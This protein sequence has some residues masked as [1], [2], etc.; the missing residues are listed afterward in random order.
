MASPRPVAAF[1]GLILTAAF[2]GPASASGQ[3][4]KAPDS[5]L[6]R[7]AFT[8]DLLAPSE[9]VAPMEDVEDTLTPEV[10]DSWHSF[11][12]DAGGQWKAYIDRR[13]GRLEIAEGSGL[14]WIPGRGNQLRLADIAPQ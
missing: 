4:V 6:D 13:S 3:G 9:V 14:P 11:Q 2:L 7:L 5:P 10:A 8:S 1:V 12:L